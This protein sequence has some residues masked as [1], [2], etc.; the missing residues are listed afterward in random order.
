MAMEMVDL[1]LTPEEAEDEAPKEPHKPKYPYGTCITLDETVLEKLGITKNLPEI[2]QTIHLDS[3]V[4]VV[5]VRE[6]EDE[7]E[8]R[9]TIELQMLNIHLN[10]GGEEKEDTESLGDQLR[11]LA[12]EH[13][14]NTA[15]KET[16][17]EE[18]AE[19][20]PE[21]TEEEEE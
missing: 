21:T 5:G 15:A 7:D 8:T 2:G 4:K 10:I 20:E 11:R 18:E 16:P 9:C 13:E 14:G 19:S 6:N 17:K 1:E 12:D 3:D